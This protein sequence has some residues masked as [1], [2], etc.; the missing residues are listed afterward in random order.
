MAH[1]KFTLDIGLRIFLALAANTTLLVAVNGRDEEQVCESTWD[2]LGLVLTVG[3][4][5]LST[6]IVL[7]V[8]RGEL[9]PLY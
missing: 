4:F 3:V 8:T 2:I 1:R 6:S 5:G 7:R 9:N